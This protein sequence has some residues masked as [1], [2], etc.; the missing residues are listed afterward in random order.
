M[1]NY[2]KENMHMPTQNVNDARRKRINLY[3][4]I[5]VAIIVALILLPTLL[6]IVLFIRIGF[7]EG[8]LKKSN[9]ELLSVEEKIEILIQEQNNWKAQQSE[10]QTDESEETT[11]ALPVDPV[12]PDFEDETQTQLSEQELISQA[13]S[14]GRKVVYLTFDDGPC[15][16]TNNLLDVLKNHDVK[17]SFFVNYHNG[18]ENEY[19]RIL[20]EGHTLAMH[21][22]SHDYGKVYGSLDQFESEVTTLQDYLFNLTGVK[23]NLFRFPGGSSNSVSKIP[24]TDCVNYLNDASITYFDWNVSSGDGSTVTK[25]QCYNN[26]INGVN[27]V[28][29]AVVLMHDSTAKLTTFEALDQILQTLQDMNALILPITADT[30][31]VKHNIN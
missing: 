27:N 25:E 23:P 17:A 16:N 3:K 20:E 21:T 26:V 13:L 8:D 7:L 12:L 5:L 9:E 11:E 30:V 31:P 18:F 2:K 15:E 24:I 29:I 1:Q 10:L 6:C 22:A 4:K 14:E 19:K 28:D